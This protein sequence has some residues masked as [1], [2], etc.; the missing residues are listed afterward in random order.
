M[1]KLIIICLSLVGLTAALNAKVSV[2]FTD[3]ENYRDIQLGATNSEKEQ[4]I[5]LS[6]V[7]KSFEN[8]AKRYLP[9]NYSLAVTVVDIDL[10]GD[11]ELPSSMGHDIRLVTDIFPP[12]INFHY[13]IRDGE[14][15]IVKKEDAK[16]VDLN[17]MYAIRT[18][19]QPT[20]EFVSELVKNWGRRTLRTTRQ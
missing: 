20:A 17:F 6:A 13:E 4:Q 2:D 15:Q 18:F 12:R 14:N 16:L 3:V 7:K 10:A 1:K 5:V 8:T 9:E 11:F 19:E